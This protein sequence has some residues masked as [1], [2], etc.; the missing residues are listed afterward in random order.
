M[1]PEDVRLSTRHTG[2]HI[3]NDSFKLP[4]RLGAR[5]PVA[6]ELSAYF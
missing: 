4:A 2:R 5:F 3:R 1:V 6:G